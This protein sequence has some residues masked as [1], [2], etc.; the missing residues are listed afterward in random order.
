MLLLAVA[1]PEQS[2]LCTNPFSFT[3]GTYMSKLLSRPYVQTSNTYTFSYVPLAAAD[4][5][6]LCCTNFTHMDSVG[7][8][9]A[10]DCLCSIPITAAYGSVQDYSMS[11]V[12]WFDI[13]ALTTQQLSFQLRDR[14]YNILSIV[15]NISFT[16]TID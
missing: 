4:V 6:Y 12:V 3:G 9:G 15:P 1:R 13:P 8:K 2:L 5:L 16:L 11:S 7:P 10:S 14:D